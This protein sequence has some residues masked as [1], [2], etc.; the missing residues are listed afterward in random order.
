[1][2]TTARRLPYLTHLR[3]FEP[4]SHLPAEQRERWTS[5]ARHAP[6]RAA[7]EGAEFDDAVRRL[8][9]TPPHPVPLTESD[10]A[11]LLEVRGELF[12]C[13]EQPL[14]RAW[15][16]LGVARDPEPLGVTVPDDDLRARAAAALAARAGEGGEVRLFTRTAA[17]QVPLAWFVPFEAGERQLDLG[18]QRALRYRTAMGRA[19][20]RLARG[21]RAAR[22]HLDDPEVVEDLELVGR[23]LE[24]FDPRSVVELDYGGLVDLLSDAH[25]RGDDSAS[26]VADGLAAL[27]EGDLT[28]AA[29]AY[30]RLSTRWDRVALLARAS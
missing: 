14:L 12:V 17:W 27:T 15:H 19:R 9:A 23:W 28:V 29:A 5:Y 7:L 26:D 3:V 1:M 10:E 16:G 6:E 30:Q 24:E 4:V 8:A 22:E 2:P 21:L 20:R 13:P 11:L 25:L 18:E